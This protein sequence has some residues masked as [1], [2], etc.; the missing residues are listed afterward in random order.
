MAKPER[1]ATRVESVMEDPNAQA[2]ARVYADAFVQAAKSSGLD[3]ALEEFSSFLDD[4][5]A[6]S[7]DFE[8]LLYSGLLSRDE[9]LAIIERV[10][11]PR[12]S[13]MFTNFLRVLARHDRLELLPTILR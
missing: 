3:G 6:K 2:V 11:A 13:E 12:G 9:K 5:V 10:V 7:P 1:G 4:V 8:R